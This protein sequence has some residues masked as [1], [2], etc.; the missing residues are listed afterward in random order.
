MKISLLSYT[1]MG[2]PNRRFAADLLVFTKNTRLK[3]TVGGLQDVHDQT[4]EDIVA[5][6]A[7][8]ADSIPSSWEFIDYVFMVEGVSRA[9]THQMVRTRTASYAQQTMRVLDVSGFEYVT[10]PTISASPCLQAKYDAMMGELNQLYK[11][12]VIDGAKIEDARGIL[13]TNICTNI[14]I[15][16]NLRTLAE[17]V[18]KRTSP[19]TQDEYQQ[20]V[21]TMRS[22]VLEAHPYFDVFLNSRANKAADKLYSFIE[23]RNHSA[24]E[25]TELIKAVDVLRK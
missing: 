16:L 6:L 13:P 7:Y 22:L 8:M 10:G 20:V 1:G 4:D 3:M 11:E 23:R 24:D 2:H 9:F 25:R 15:K 12:L 19:R 18:V 17:M 5:Q 21:S 14:V